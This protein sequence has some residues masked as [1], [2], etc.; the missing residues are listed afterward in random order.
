M[1]PFDVLL[2]NALQKGFNQSA[3]VQVRQATLSGN[4]GL[5]LITLEDG[6][7]FSIL[8]EPTV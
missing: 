7:K 3:Q 6:R 8:Y 4:T 1:A 2:N 5:L